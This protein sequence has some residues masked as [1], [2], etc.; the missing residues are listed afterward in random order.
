[1][2]KEQIAEL[3]VKAREDSALWEEIKQRELEIEKRLADAERQGK[4]VDDTDA[5]LDPPK[6]PTLE[7][8]ASDLIK[9]RYGPNEIFDRG[10]LIMV[11]RRAAR[12]D[13]GL[14]V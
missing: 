5:V 4:D 12:I 1:M 10:S 2:A 9:R 13:L 14:P 3:V 8:I 11:L 7:A 6:M